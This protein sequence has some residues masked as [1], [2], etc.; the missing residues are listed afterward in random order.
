MPPMLGIILYSIIS[1][2]GKPLLNFAEG[3]KKG[4]QWSSIIMA[5]G[6]LAIGSAMTNGM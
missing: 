3:M 5:A 1:F 6:T 2:D 4:V